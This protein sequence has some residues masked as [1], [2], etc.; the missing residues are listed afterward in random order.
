MFNLQQTWGCPRIHNSFGKSCF[1][2][3]TV[4]GLHAWW[5]VLPQETWPCRGSI[6]SWLLLNQGRL[7][8]RYKKNLRCLCCLT[9]GFK[10]RYFS[11]LFCHY[12]WDDI[13]DRKEKESF[14][15]WHN[16][17]LIGMSNYYLN[18]WVLIQIHCGNTCN[19]KID[20]GDQFVWRPNGFFFFFIKLLVDLSSTGCMQKVS[21]QQCHRVQS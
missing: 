19:I 16:A 12:L 5:L 3:R 8:K 20:S 1:C 2:E 14:S 17:N 11:R 10:E 6:N 4:A 9:I 15:V 21:P 7:Q 13:A 18:G